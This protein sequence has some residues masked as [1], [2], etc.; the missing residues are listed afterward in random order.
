MSEIQWF[1]LDA[2]NKE[3]GPYLM[4][5]MH[6]LASGGHFDSETLLWYEGLEEWSPAGHFPDIAPHLPAPAPAPVATPAAAP[7][8]YPATPYGI[9]GYGIQGAINLTA[10]PGGEYPFP[11]V[12]PASF[13]KF[14]SFLI[15]GFITICLALLILNASG[16]DTVASAA[17][18][19]SGQEAEAYESS[20]TSVLFAFGLLAL[21]LLLFIIARILSLIYLYRAWAA[22]QRGQARTTP[23]AAVGFLFIP[24][25]NLYWIFVAFPGWASDWKRIRTSY[26]NLLG[27]PAVSPGL[28]LTMIIC[29][30]SVIGIP[31]AIVLSFI[32]MNQMC[33]VVNFMAAGHSRQQM[34]QSSGG[35]K[36]Y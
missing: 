9:Q 11:N 10:P 14:L 4:S 21:G 19:P 36:F 24:L 15:G 17:E 31:I 5:Q 34:G 20:N 6:E 29:A 13:G 25:F 8:A 1:Y 18:L 12:K 7:A 16:S 27:A 26:T 33:Q 22:L 30:F 28:F 2:S 35:M 3:Q 32:C 23:G